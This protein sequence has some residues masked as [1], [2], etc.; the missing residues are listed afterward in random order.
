MRGA[1]VLTP[2]GVG[3]RYPSDAPEILPGGEIDAIRLAREVR[4]S[5]KALLLDYL[6]GNA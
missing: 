2:F 3:V 6:D 1:N 5:V 4:E